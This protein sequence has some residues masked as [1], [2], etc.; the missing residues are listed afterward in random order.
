MNHF[1][2]ILMTGAAIAALIFSASAAAQQPAQPATDGEANAGAIVACMNL[3]KDAQAQTACVLGV[4]LTTLAARAPAVAQASAPTPL[5]VQQPQQQ[6][7]WLGH[8]GDAIAGVLMPVKDTAIALAPAVAQVLVSRTNARTQE[9]VA[10]FNRDATIA[11]Y[12]AFTAMGAQVRDAGVHGYQ[13]VQAP[14]AT[15]T[16]SGTGVIGSG[17]YVGP[18]TTTTTTTT[19]CTGGQAGNGGGT[20]TG[21]AGGAGGANDC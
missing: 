21:A 4:A 7:S 16:L 11:G 9:A 10:G 2:R 14:G 15:T 20:T 8:I 19:T 5:I 3:G 1:K 13:F 17:S 18:T 12:Q 6:R